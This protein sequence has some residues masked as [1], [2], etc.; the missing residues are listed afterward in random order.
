MSR[1]Q[2]LAPVQQAALPAILN[3]LGL[4]NAKLKQTELK[5]LCNI[6]N[7]VPYDHRTDS[8]IL[9]SNL[10]L[11]QLGIRALSRAET[12]KTISESPALQKMVQELLSTVQTL[13]PRAK[14]GAAQ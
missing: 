2:T 1:C 7:S 10:E 3:I 11:A 4:A 6:Y 9:A 14:P 8:Q 13:L 12:M 5:S